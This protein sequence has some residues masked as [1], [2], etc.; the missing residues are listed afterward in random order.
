MRGAPPADLEALEQLLVRLSRLVLVQPA[1]A[2]ED[3]NPLLVRI[4]FADD[5]RELALAVVAAQFGVADRPGG[6]RQAALDQ[7]VSLQGRCDRHQPRLRL[8]MA[9]AGVVPSEGRIQHQPG[10]RHRPAPAQRFSH[11][12]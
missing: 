7:A 8:R 11:N 5:D 12:R 9:A 6:D 3:R 1:I 4:C 10:G 2:V